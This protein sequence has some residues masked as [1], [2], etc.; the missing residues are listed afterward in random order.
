[1]AYD[2]ETTFNSIILSIEEGSSLR[3]TLLREGMPTSIT[4][5]SWIDKDE[6]K[7]LH[8][9]RA[10]EKRAEVIFE[11]ILTIADDSKGDKKYT[12]SGE[13]MDAEYVARSR[14]RI[15]ARKWM[16]SKMQPKKYGDKTDITSGG[17]KI[18]SNDIKIEIVR[19]DESDDSI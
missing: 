4:F 10:C 17:E 5:Y 1:M 12:E 6:I 2:K 7:M 15:D 3:A 16:L 18:Q 11:D 8:Y 13:F 19:P 9:V 14:I